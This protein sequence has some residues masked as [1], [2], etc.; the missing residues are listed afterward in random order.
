MAAKKTKKVTITMDVETLEKLLDAL[1]T[2]GSPGHTFEHFVDD[3]D[4]A[5]KLKKRSKKR[6]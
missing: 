2:L 4:V 3:P 6:R 1:D 5:R